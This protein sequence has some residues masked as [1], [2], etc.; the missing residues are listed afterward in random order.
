MHPPDTGD[1]GRPI[2]LDEAE[3]LLRC[4]CFKNGPPRAVGVEVEWLIHELERPER[5]VPP[6]ASPRP[7]TRYVRYN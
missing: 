4:I 7:I 2:D 1:F 5:P 3:D 6:T